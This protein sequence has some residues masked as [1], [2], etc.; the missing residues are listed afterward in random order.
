VGFISSSKLVVYFLS[1]SFDAVKETYIIAFELASVDE[2]G[3]F[4]DLFCSFGIKKQQHWGLDF[5]KKAADH[6]GWKE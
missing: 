1:L 5:S 2:D 6:I 3:F 4:N